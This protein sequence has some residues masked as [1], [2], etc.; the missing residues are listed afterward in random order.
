M[1]EL[2]SLRG[3]RR[4]CVDLTHWLIEDGM[5]QDRRLV[6]AVQAGDFGLRDFMDR[7]G[8]K[9]TRWWMEYQSNE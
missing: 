2:I 1:R 7:M 3:S 8:G 9:M 5:L 6:G 4:A